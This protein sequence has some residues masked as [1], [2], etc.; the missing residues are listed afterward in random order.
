MCFRIRFLLFFFI[1]VPNTILMAADFLQPSMKKNWQLILPALKVPPKWNST[2]SF[3]DAC[4][5]SLNQQFDG[6]L[7]EVV[8]VTDLKFYDSTAGKKRDL[9]IEPETPVNTG[10]NK[11]GDTL[12]FWLK[13]R[14]GFKYSR[15]AIPLKREMY[16]TL[17]DSIAYAVYKTA[18]SEFLGELQLQGGPAGCTMSISNVFDITPPCKL[19][20]PVGVYNIVTHYPNFTTRNDSVSVYAGESIIKRILLLPVE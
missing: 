9:I 15:I 7:Y 5:Q 4:Y 14:T 1:F 13:F 3:Q 6:T 19:R 18:Q 2:V 8:K 11:S 20:L 17:T 12:A 10:K 16:T